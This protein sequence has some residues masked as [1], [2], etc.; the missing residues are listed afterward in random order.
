MTTERV[1]TGRPLGAIRLEPVVELPEGLAPETIEAPLRVRSDCDQA[2]VSQ[3]PQV[4]R[5]ARLAHP[6]ILNELAY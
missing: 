5:D 3:H 1:E 6:E 2:R 4:P